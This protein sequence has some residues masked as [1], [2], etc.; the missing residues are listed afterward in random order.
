M[1]EKKET[2]IN[3]YELTNREHEVL[4]LIAE[5]LSNFEMNIFSSAKKPLNRTSATF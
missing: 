5:G 4:T 3:L 2:K 1:R